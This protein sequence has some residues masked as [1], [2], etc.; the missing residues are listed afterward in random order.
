MT[1]VKVLSILDPDSAA[2]A[3][4]VLLE[5]LEASEGTSKDALWNLALLY[6]ETKRQDEAFSCI[7]RLAALTR[8]PDEEA[9]CFLAQGQLCEQV[10]DFEGAIRYYRT[11]HAMKREH[12]PS[13]YWFNNNLGYS[14]VR[15]GQ[16]G[17]ALGYLRTAIAI[18]PRRSNAYKNM[19]LAL[20]LLGDYAEA[21]RSFLSA[22]Q[23]N[24]DDGRALRHLEELLGAHPDV[25]PAVP[26]LASELAS[27]RNR[28]ARIAN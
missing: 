15:L 2:K 4:K 23:A 25:L 28:A 18:H 1:S 22:T 6:S 24:P 17:E 11:G 10:T 13:W 21:A 7:Q 26:D 5:K 3:E 9:A 8:D 27:W 19:G 20:T 14:L 12:A 16:A